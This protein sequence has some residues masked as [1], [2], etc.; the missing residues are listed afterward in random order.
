MTQNKKKPRSAGLFFYG[1]VGSLCGG[2][3]RTRPRA[4]NFFVDFK[5]A[6]ISAECTGISKKA[7]IE[8]NQATLLGMPIMMR[9]SVL[10]QKE[11]T[12]CAVATES[13][14][15]QKVWRCCFR[16]NSAGRMPI[17]ALVSVNRGI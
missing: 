3:C 16:K 11:H 5:S 17:S 15:F 2:A 14:V 6:K 7:L 9:M 12:S 13:S 4:R 10:K 8:R 1:L